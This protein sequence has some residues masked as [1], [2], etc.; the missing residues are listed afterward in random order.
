METSTPLPTTTLTSPKRK[1]DTKDP[2]DQALV[3]PTARLR[4]ADL[5][6]TNT[7]SSVEREYTGEGSPRTTVA[8]NFQNLNLTGQTFDFGQL[9]R[10]QQQQQQQPPE[11]AMAV[12][13]F[14][15]AGGS[16]PANH[17]QHQQQQQ[18]QQEAAHSGLTPNTLSA[19]NPPFFKPDSNTIDLPPEV[20]ETPRL[21]PTNAPSPLLS[22]VSRCKSPPPMN[23]WWAEAEITGHN[24]TDPA[25]DGYG[26]NGVG[27]LPT[28]ATA[29]A[30]AERRKKQVA[31]WKNRE[32]KEARQKRSD[33]RRRRDT[34]LGA[35]GGSA[36]GGGSMP[37][38]RVRFLEV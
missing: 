24:P 21:R 8:R 3:P 15:R 4:I 12:S 34:E 18:Q 1:R 20:P 17:H 11:P 23:L 38:R 28:P 27:F 10:E 36:T 14:D 22:P 5:P 7:C 16:L 30:R 9:L 31:E 29:N 35:E 25:D 33:R 26:I 13:G 37:E 32:A 2:L 6:T 19:I